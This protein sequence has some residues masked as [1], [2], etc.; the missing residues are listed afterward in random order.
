[1]IESSGGDY[2]RQVPAYVSRVCMDNRYMV[3]GVDVNPIN[4]RMY[5]D[6]E[7]GCIDK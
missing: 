2:E 4:L 3:Y 6:N 1:V 7:N 5:N